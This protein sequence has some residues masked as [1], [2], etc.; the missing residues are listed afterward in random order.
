MDTFALSPVIEEGSG[1][2]HPGEDG[3][4]GHGLTAHQPEAKEPQPKEQPSNETPT[5]KAASAQQIE[6]SS[7]DD[8]DEEP[9]PAPPPM[10]LRPKTKEEEAR[11]A[12]QLKREREKLLASQRE[13]AFCAVGLRR[14][15]RHFLWSFQ[16][17]STLSVH[18][19]KCLRHIHSPAIS[20]E[21][22]DIGR[23]VSRVRAPGVKAVADAHTSVQASK[24]IVARIQKPGT[25]AEW[26][27][28]FE[29]FAN[30]RT[31]FRS[32]FSLSC[33]GLNDVICS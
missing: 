7:D 31:A 26:E 27:N 21:E 5:S 13:A 28:A 2:G 8:D 15:R 30:V 22:S 1:S 19:P 18:H 11:E 9:L 14:C 32:Q 25:R 3:T 17:E 33:R 6:Q 12:E 24:A 10:H 16:A 20:F 29:S 23:V 4:V